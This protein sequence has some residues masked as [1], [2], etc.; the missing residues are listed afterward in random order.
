MCLCSDSEAI[1]QQHYCDPSQQLSAIDCVLCVNRWNG[2]V[3]LGS[4]EAESH[5]FKDTDEGQETIYS[6][7]TEIKK[8][9]FLF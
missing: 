6:T 7:Q 4:F 1:E 3:I 9:F 2:W 5:G 8:R